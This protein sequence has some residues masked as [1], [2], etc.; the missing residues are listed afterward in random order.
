VY[1]GAVS[2]T[3]PDRVYLRVSRETETDD[4]STTWDDSLLVSEDGGKAFRE[5]L[6]RQASLL[7][8]AVSADGNTVAAG[9]GD[10]EIAPIIV[11]DTDLGLYGASASD[12]TFTQ[13]VGSIAVSCLRWTPS[14]LYVCA[15]ESDP[16]GIDTSGT[17][18]FHVALWKGSG[19]PQ[20]LAD[21]RPL[22]K[23]K[24]VRGPLPWADNRSSAC[25]AEWSTGDPANPGTPSVCQNFNACTRGGTT[26]LA[27]G[28]IVCGATAS[29]AS[30]AP[31]G[32]GCRVRPQ[33][34]S[35][36]LVIWCALALLAFAARRKKA[37]SL[38]RMP[39]FT[40]APTR[41]PAGLPGQPAK[42]LL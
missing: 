20:N 24:D 7:G 31:S 11:T 27:A 25:A 23:L 34:N 21:F 6:R 15:K 41:T 32:C 37:L 39:A 36:G 2:P 40:L 5:V 33:K 10:P 14:G 29:G 13:R 18:D 19:L 26:T 38:D 16:L 1:I 4:G 3:D 17:P 22:L 30:S 28:A 9:Y 12:L 42:A 8:F 35:P